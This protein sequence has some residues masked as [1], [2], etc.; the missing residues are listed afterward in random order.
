EPASAVINRHTSMSTVKVDAESHYTLVELRDVRESCLDI[1]DVDALREYVAD[2]APVEYAPD[3]EFQYGSLLA[4]KVR[5]N[6]PDYSPKA[7]YLATPTGDR[8]KI[9]KP[10]INDT[11]L[12]PP[13][14]IEVRNP[15]NP[16]ELLAYCWYASKGRNILGKIRP[17]GKI[18]AVDGDQP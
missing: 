11:L 14:F 15:D 16:Q 1:L 9:Y 18:F 8:I 12:A 13:D 2:I 5:E 4:G 7:I 6:V 17:A 10:Y 3:S